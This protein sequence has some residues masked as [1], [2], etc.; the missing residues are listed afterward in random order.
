MWLEWHADLLVIRVANKTL[1]SRRR[2]DIVPETFKRWGL[3]VATSVLI[4]VLWDIP[5][6]SCPLLTQMVAIS[7]RY[8]HGSKSS[9]IAPDFNKNKVP[10][11]AA[12]PAIIACYMS[13]ACAKSVTIFGTPVQVEEDANGRFELH[14]LSAF[15]LGFN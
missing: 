2:Q 14:S 11:P 1:S 5:G 3:T 4:C 10:S 6:L 9:S 13:C 15:C 8:T 12:F 7:L